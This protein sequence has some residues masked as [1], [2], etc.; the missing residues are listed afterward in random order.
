VCHRHPVRLGVERDRLVEVGHR[1]ADVVDGGEEVLHV[2][3]AHGAHC[4]D[5]GL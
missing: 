3:Q 1:D 5:V 4:A 2:A